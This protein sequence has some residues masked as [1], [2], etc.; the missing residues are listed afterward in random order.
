LESNGIAGAL[1][2]D[3]QEEAL[4]CSREG[5]EIDRSILSEKLLDIDGTLLER[6]RACIS[7]LHLLA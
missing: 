1:F 2:R 6:M 3:F 5:T 7:P 4:T